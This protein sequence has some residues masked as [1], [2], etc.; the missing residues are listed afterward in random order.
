MQL[1]DAITVLTV[2]VPSGAVHQF[3]TDRARTRICS[4]LSG[5]VRVQVA[6][7]PEFV[8]GSHGIFKIAPGASCSVSN[9]C[10]FDVVLHVTSLEEA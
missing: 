8:V 3:Q 1:S 6:G 7:E 4:L 2:I 10:Y 9:R 5:K